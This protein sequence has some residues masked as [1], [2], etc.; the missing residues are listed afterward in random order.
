MTGRIAHGKTVSA[1]PSQGAA[2]HRV[3]ARS[4]TGSID[5]FYL[6][7]A[8]G[9]DRVGALQLLPD[10]SQPEDNKQTRKGCDGI[11]F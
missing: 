7:A 3:A 4:K 9:R 1:R 6:P 5:A 8:N 11:P 2:P 10:G